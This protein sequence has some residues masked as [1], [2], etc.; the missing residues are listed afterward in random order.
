MTVTSSCSLFIWRTSHGWQPE[1][2]TE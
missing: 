2:C 1:D